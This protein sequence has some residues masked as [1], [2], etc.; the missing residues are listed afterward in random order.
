MMTVF[1]F[2]IIF[3]FITLRAE[4]YKRLSYDFSSYK[5]NNVDT[6]SYDDYVTHLWSYDRF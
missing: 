4:K 1:A 6:K 2:I 5:I 3:Y